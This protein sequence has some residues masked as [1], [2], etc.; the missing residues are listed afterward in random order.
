MPDLGQ[1]NHR[2]IEVIFQEIETKKFEMKQPGADV[3]ALKAKIQELIAELIAA[4]GLRPQSHGQKG[5]PPQHITNMQNTNQITEDTSVNLQTVPT[6]DAGA[7][8]ENLMF[9]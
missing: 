7:S 1:I 9:L 4:G 6:I 2:P 8:N 3:G 5:S